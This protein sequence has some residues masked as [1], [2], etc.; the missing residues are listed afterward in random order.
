[1]GGV[2]LS[3]SRIYFWFF[4]WFLHCFFFYDHTRSFDNYFLQTII[5]DFTE[6]GI[7]AKFT[8]LEDG[9]YLSK[10]WD[11]SSSKEPKPTN[12][13]CVFETGNT[14]AEHF[15]AFG[16]YFKLSDFCSWSNDLRRIIDQATEINDIFRKFNSTD[17]DAKFGHIDLKCKSAKFPFKTSALMKSV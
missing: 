1:M 3:R 10:L 9:L 17:F 15:I 6:Q 4:V 11:T 12:G 16:L 13:T 5:A 14:P 7:R 8:L 2:M